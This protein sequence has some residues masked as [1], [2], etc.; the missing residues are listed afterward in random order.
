MAQA[1]ACP[2]TPS[3]R[4]RGPAI[5]P[6]RRTLPEVLRRVVKVKDT[7]GID[8]ELLLKEAPQP[9][10]AITEPDDLGGTPD[11]LPQ[12]FQPQTRLAGV[13]IAQDSH[14]PALRQPGHP[15]PCPHMMRAQ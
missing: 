7:R 14:E 2:S 8:R 12:R 5:K 1:M 9:P 11:A 4:M 6:G 10:P 13:H 3:T 15:L